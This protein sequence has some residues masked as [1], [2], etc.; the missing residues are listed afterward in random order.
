MGIPLKLRAAVA[1]LPRWKRKSGVRSNKSGEREQGRGRTLDMRPAYNSLRPLA[2]E[3]NSRSRAASPATPAAGS[4]CGRVRRLATLA[5]GLPATRS[6]ARMRRVRLRS[7]PSALAAATRTPRARSMTRRRLA[8]AAAAL[9]AAVVVSV[10]ILTQTNSP[11]CAHTT[12]TARNTQR[13]PSAA[14]PAYRGLMRTRSWSC[15]CP[16]GTRAQRPSGWF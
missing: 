1:R 13:R 12:A 4:T 9:V 14:I 8:L 11:L 2:E 16:A 6:P 5:R 10:A 15:L 7:A 3:E